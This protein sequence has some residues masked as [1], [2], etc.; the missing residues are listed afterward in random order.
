MIA[1]FNRISPTIATTAWVAMN[2]TVIGD[3]TVGDGVGVFY[4]AVLRG[5]A[6]A[7]AVGANSNV[8]DGVVLHA[9]PGYPLR[10]GSGVSIGHNAVLHGCTIGD[11]VL[12]GMGATVLNGA[13]V[14]AGSI[15]G[16]N[17]LVPEGTE[18]P[19]GSLVVGVPAKVR[20]E[21]T[22]D[23]LAKVRFNAE[24]YVAL[25]QQHAAD[26]AARV[27]NMTGPSPTGR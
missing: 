18:I 1:D 22:D 6:A 12:V 3:V 21:L 5:D 25:T 15:I 7:V 14:G 8:Q 16:A 19:A 17:A 2:A 4:H 20:R 13:S 27:S 23:E 9:D 24:A 26:E 10:V 11:D